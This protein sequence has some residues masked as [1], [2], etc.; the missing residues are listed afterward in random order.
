ME[1]TQFRYMKLSMELVFDLEL[2]LTLYV[3]ERHCQAS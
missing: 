3:Y 1:V 2:F